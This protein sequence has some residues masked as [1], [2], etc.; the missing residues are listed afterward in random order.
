VGFFIHDEPPLQETCEDEREQGGCAGEGEREHRDDVAACGA[1]AFRLGWRDAHGEDES[2]A[3]VT[4]YVGH[5]V[6]SCRSYRSGGYVVYAFL[7][8]MLAG[9]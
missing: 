2:F 8:V 3:E 5:G 9:A 1:R 6:F 4:A 7:A